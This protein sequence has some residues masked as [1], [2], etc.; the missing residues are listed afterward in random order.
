M[1][2]Y[3]LDEILK[4]PELESFHK[5]TGSWDAIT[6]WRV[7]DRDHFNDILSKI[8]KNPMVEQT[9]SQLVLQTFKDNGD[10]NPLL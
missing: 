2:H 8:A 7:K 1:E 9:S 10:F 5:I 4:S 6:Y 3:R